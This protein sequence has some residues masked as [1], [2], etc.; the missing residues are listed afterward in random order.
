MMKDLLGNNNIVRDARL[1][2]KLLW[3]QKKINEYK[4]GQIL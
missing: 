4:K 3:R 1:W 2:D